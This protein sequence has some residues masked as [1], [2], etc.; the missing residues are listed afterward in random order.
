MATF[1]NS[2]FLS[3]AY[4]FWLATKG[5]TRKVQGRLND[6]GMLLATHAQRDGTTGKFTPACVELLTDV[7]RWVRLYH[8][9]FWAGQVR[10]ARGDEGVSLSVLRTEIGLEAL[11]ERGA[12]TAKEH[13]LLVHN[14]ALTETGRFS[15]VL[16]WIVT[17]FV[18]A[19]RGGLLHG[20]VALEARFLEEACK[21]RATTASIAD[22]AAAR[23]PL[24][25][26]HLVQLLVDCLV[27]LAPFAL[28]PKL[29]VL[30]ALLS[31]IL[32]IFY[33]GFLQLSKSLLDPFGNEDSTDENFNVFTLI[34]ETNK[35]SLRW[36]QSVEEL[37]FT[38]VAGTGRSIFG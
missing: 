33:R 4:G 38:P 31:P 17:R 1:V 23:M 26:V 34:C 29:G 32:V 37:P 36:F 24:A 11:R 7:A 16:E 30:T 13:A 21:L 6:M 19:Q 9:L 35:G 10:P 22:D 8:V 18:D 27:V 14:P 28:Y 3:Q 25:Y 20:S 2:F 12:L 5:N 15:A